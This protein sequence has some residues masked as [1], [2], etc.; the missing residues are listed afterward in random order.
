MPR[1]FSFSVTHIYT[2]LPSVSSGLHSKNFETAD[3]LVQDVIYTANYLSAREV[4]LFQQS[5]RGGY[6]S[7]PTASARENANV[8]PRST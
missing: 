5:N 3:A 6:L 1:Y 7:A 2:F 4:E 8:L